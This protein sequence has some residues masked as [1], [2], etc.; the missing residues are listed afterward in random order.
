MEVQDEGIGVEE[1]FVCNK[2]QLHLVSLCWARRECGKTN[3]ISETFHIRVSRFNLPSS[4]IFN[5]CWV[6][7][8]L[9][10]SKPIIVRVDV[11]RYKSHVIVF[12][13]ILCLIIRILIIFL[14]LL[15]ESITPL[16]LKSIEKY[17]LNLELNQFTRRKLVSKNRAWFIHC[18]KILIWKQDLS[19]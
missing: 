2:N 19:I 13:F 15:C 9:W 1:E 11:V 17:L 4:I 7:T 14:C 5:G 10:G 18:H 6:F 3:S 12:V 8:G 16:I